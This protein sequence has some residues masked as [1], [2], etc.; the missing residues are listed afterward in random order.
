MTV[1]SEYSLVQY[2][3]AKIVIETI[4]YSTYV[5]QLTDKIFLFTVKHSIHVSAYCTFLP[6]L[7]VCR[8][9]H[10]KNQVGK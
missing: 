10:R 8:V 1:R 5:N 9:L 4:M 7:S 6:F 2:S 3:T